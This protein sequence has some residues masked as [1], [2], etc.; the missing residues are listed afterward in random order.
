MD[1]NPRPLSATLDFMSDARILCIGDTMLDHFV[2]GSV[3]RI[4][5]EA[6]TPI[7]RSTS[8]RY[9]LGGAGNVLRNIISL[10]AH[11]SFVSVIGND[12]A[13][14]QL[15]AMVG[16]EER[17]EACLVTDADRPTT[18]KTR[19][20]ASGQQIFRTD[21]ES[22]EALSDVMEQKLL[23]LITPLLPE[24]DVVL[25]SDYAKG[26]LTE[27]LVKQV[28]A[29]AKAAEKPVV[30][31]P[32]STDFAR[33]HGATLLSPNLKELQ[34]ASR[35]PCASEQEII[36]A[37]TTL[38]KTHDIT[39]MLVTRGADGMTLLESGAEPLHIR[40]TAREV[41]D[42]T[43]AGDSVIATL[44]VAMACSTPLA[45]AAVLAN[46]AG[47]IAVSRSGTTTVYR[48][49]IRQALHTRESDL[50]N[51][52]ILPLDVAIETI[53]SLKHD[54]K[55][56]GFTNGCFDILHTGHLSL[57]EQAKATCDFLVVG[58]NSDSS[59]R[60]LKGESRPINDEISRALLLAGITYVDMVVIFRDDTPLALIEAFQPDTLIKGADYTIDT[61]V[62]ADIVQSY[63]GQV[64]LAELTPNKSTTGTI[65]KIAGLT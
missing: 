40:A 64:V 51:T 58:L 6:P 35:L 48:T 46:T 60:R 38:M 44:A 49:E 17:T 53:T 28:I 14:H 7:L 52:K 4:S 63:G 31:D 65:G 57:M 18:V 33:Y 13:G 39:H 9:T 15:T 27:S 36:A 3:D 8:E 12:E 16:K 26:V 50:A 43:G 19:F 24:C 23:N 34:A 42:V 32:K 54:G 55:S 29:A 21:R 11:A 59:I 61:V 10:G 62:G 5:P 41:Y 20:L 56:I 30:I 47:A 22:S 25:L 2:T 45:D 37:A 1:D